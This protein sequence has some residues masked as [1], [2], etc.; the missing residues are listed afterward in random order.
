MIRAASLATFGALVLTGCGG[1]VEKATDLRPQLL[2]MSC[3]QFNTYVTTGSDYRVR[4]VEVDGDGGVSPNGLSEA[5]YARSVCLLAWATGESGDTVVAWVSRATGERKSPPSNQSPPS[6]AAAAN[7]VQGSYSNVRHGHIFMPISG[8]SDCTLSASFSTCF[9]EAPA[10]FWV[11]DD[12]F[13]DFRW[14]GWGKS[15][16]VGIGILASQHK[17]L[18]VTLSQPGT[19]YG[20][21]TVYLE[22]AWV[23]K[24]VTIVGVAGNPAYIGPGPAGSARAGNPSGACTYQ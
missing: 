1:S 2:S 8:E 6:S 20:P 23:P 9:G 19:C 5:V 18:T 10:Q 12:Q 21:Q 13:I 17:R 14:S 16:A 11:G 4:V 24:R 15:V 22:M 7:S 3:A